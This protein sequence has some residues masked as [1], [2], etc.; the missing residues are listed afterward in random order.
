MELAVIVV[1]AEQT[2]QTWNAGSAELW[3]VRSEEARGQHLWGLDIGL[4]MDGVRTGLRAVL[5]GRRERA[6]I[7]LD[8]TNRRGRAVRLRV[9]CLPLGAV[10]GSAG[11]AIVLAEVAGAADGDAA[12]S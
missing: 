4:P 1:D 10:D 3:G 2:V 5:S 12:A 9:T 8:A 7:E 6:D 11:G